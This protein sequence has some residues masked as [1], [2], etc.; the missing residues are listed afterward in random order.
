[1]KRVRSMLLIL[2]LAGS[3][4]S[5]AQNWNA[6]QKEAWSTVEAYWAAQSKGDV[7]GFL[8]Y[9]SPDYL[10]WGYESPVP[11]NKAAVEKYVSY[12]MKN[13][14]ILMYDITPV[15]ILVYDDIAIVHYYYNMQ[16]ENLEGKKS[17][18]HGRWTDILQRQAGKWLLVSDHGGEMKDK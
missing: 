15:A 5:F 18:E 7:P 2:F 11:Q 3:T 17:W 13:N 8:A 1:M 14:K 16:L 6:Q 9:F 10:G 4:L 12:G